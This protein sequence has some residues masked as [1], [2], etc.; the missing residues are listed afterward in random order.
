MRRKAV[1]FLYWPWKISLGLFLT[2][3][4]SDTYSRSWDLAGSSS[5]NIHSMLARFS[6]PSPLSRFSQFL[7]VLIRRYCLWNKINDSCVY[8]GVVGH[9]DFSRGDRGL[10][11]SHLP[12]TNTTSISSCAQLCSILMISKKLLSRGE[13]NNL[14]AAVFS[15][16]LTIP[17]FSARGA[18]LS[19]TTLYAFSSHSRDW[20]HS[21]PAT[22]GA[23]HCRSFYNSTI[24]LTAFMSSICILLNYSPNQK[25]FNRQSCKLCWL[26]CLRILGFAWSIFRF[27]SYTSGIFPDINLQL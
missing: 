24:R 3:S 4:R 16:S 18:C 26:G 27:L 2:F 6:S 8:M 20:C 10:G 12:T 19:H 1:K 7:L 21:P 17:T 14:K 9:W 5:S 25:A 23:S 11:G 15:N 22:A 13:N